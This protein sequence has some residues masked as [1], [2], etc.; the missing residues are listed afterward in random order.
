MT[1]SL[2]KFF[3]HLSKS[4]ELVRIKLL[5]IS[6]RFFFIGS[7]CGVLWS[8]LQQ[9]VAH[10][11]VILLIMLLPAHLALHRISH[12]LVFADSNVVTDALL[13]WREP[14]H[15]CVVFAPVNSKG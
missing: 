1:L 7:I 15:N 14:L 5:C 4:L 11:H 13:D 9:H 10:K 2:N 3:I 8:L 12:D 6:G